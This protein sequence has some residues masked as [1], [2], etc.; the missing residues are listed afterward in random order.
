MNANFDIAERLSVEEK[1]VYDLGIHFSSL[2][3]KLKLTK[4]NKTAMRFLGLAK[5]YNSIGKYEEAQIYGNSA[6]NLVS[7]N[8]S[9]CALVLEC[10]METFFMHSSFVDIENREI[11]EKDNNGGENEQDQDQSHEP[12]QTATTTSISRK[13]DVD[14]NVIDLYNQA[15]DVIRFHLSEDHLFYI[16]ILSKLSELYIKCEEYE[17]GYEIHKECLECSYRLLGKNHQLTGK[18]VSKVNLI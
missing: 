4:N 8:H 1:E 14:E 15:V 10:L 13:Y 2:G 11:S 6:L 7:K 17:K 9:Y 16:N 18:H 3:R 12:D 5:Y